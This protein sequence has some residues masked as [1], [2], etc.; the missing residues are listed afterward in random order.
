MKRHYGKFPSRRVPDQRYP[1]PIWF[2][3]W[4]L[5][6]SRRQNFRILAIYSP[7]YFLTIR[8]LLESLQLWSVVFSLFFKSSSMSSRLSQS[9]TFLSS[10]LI[11]SH[12]V[13]KL[14]LNQLSISLYQEVPNPHHSVS[15]C[16]YR[17]IFISWGHNCNAVCLMRWNMY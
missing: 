2:G 14:S 7:I 6:I 8:N 3:N 10:W 11:T 1:E 4:H 13:V 16:R 5:H 12:L 17:V 9:F 15:L